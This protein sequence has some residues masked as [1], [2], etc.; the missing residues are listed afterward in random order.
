MT[1]LKP[2]A[3][4]L[5]LLG[6]IGAANAVTIFDASR[7][8]TAQE[9][10]KMLAANKNLLATR[11]ELG[12]TPL[13][14]A[15]TNSD[16]E[17]AKLLVAKGA[18]VNA[19]DNNSATPLHLAAFTGKKEL[20]EFFLAHGADAYAKDWKGQTPRDYAHHS[21]NNEIRGILAMWMLKNPQPAN[22]K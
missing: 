19:K 1:R 14:M 22:K 16:P 13:H 15:A 4:A 8:G 17:V 11:S 21:L 12:S 5:L 18:N 20:V 10:G 7:D 2:L 9:V 3:A 6:M